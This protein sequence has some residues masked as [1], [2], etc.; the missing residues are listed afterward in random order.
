M[1]TTGVARLGSVFLVVLFVFF[2]SG[3]VS[4]GI[5]CGSG[6]SITGFLTTS[7]SIQS[8]DKK[9]ASSPNALFLSTTLGC[10]SDCGH[11]KHEEIQKNF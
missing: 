4:T 11:I 9:P 5:S 2:S 7:T 1:T 8:H 6:F 10:L 3:G